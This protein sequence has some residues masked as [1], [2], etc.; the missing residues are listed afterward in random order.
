MQTLEN[1]DLFML[2]MDGT[3]YLGEQ[4]LEGAQKFVDLMRET[5]T[6]FLFLTNNSSKNRTDYLQ[7]MQR[8]GFDFDPDQIMSSGEA[9][10]R[11]VHQEY[12][13]PKVYLV[14]TPSLMEQFEQANIDLT[15]QQPD[16][17]VLGFDTTLT[18]EKI[19][20]LCDFVRAGVPFIAT[21]PDK[22]CPIPNGM[23]PDIGGMLAMVKACTDRDPD[24]IIGK[25]NSY[26]A[27]AVSEKFDVP[28]SRMA[29][30]GDR[31][32]TDIAI[33][34][35][36]GIASVLVLSGEATMA[37]LADSSV[38]PDYIFDHIGALADAI[39]TAKQAVTEAK[40]EE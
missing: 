28:L 20:K 3:F 8:L 24:V 31:L 11:Y 19:W 6:K 17:V 2:D 21:H 26:I 34:K 33:G 29:M 27:K 16:C 10:I 7:K 38:Q 40:V 1:I 9:A 23:M 22:N 37:D 5:N 14:G 36:A 13:D 4:L 39:A 30:V 32:Y 12:Q 15:D 25:P 18:Y 35:N